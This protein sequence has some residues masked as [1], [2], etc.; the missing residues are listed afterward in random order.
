MIIKIIKK[1]VKIFYITFRLYAISKKLL[2]QRIKIKNFSPIDRNGFI[3]EF[4]FAFH[5]DIIELNN[6]RFGN[7]TPHSLF[8]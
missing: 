1:R 7:L 4:K 3:K 2:L 8:Y 5:F 6:R